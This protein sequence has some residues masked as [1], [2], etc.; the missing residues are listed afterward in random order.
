MASKILTEAS[1]KVG[2]DQEER[3]ALECNHYDLCKIDV[4]STGFSV[5]SDFIEKAFTS[6]EAGF[7]LPLPRVRV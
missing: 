4:Q 2:V 3:I 5:I 7:R 6:A 1:C